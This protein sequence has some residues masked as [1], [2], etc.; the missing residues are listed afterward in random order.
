[1]EHSTDRRPRQIV[2]AGCVAILTGACSDLPSKGEALKIVR[3]EVKEEASCTL[4]ISLFSRLKMQHSSKAV[5]VP[6]EGGA[7]MDEAIKC[8]DALV[9]A[10]KTKHM[11]A[12]YMANWPDELEGPG[13]DSVSP[14]ER[15]ARYHLFK[16][17][18][19]MTGD[20]REGR[21]RCGEA[22]AEKV[23]RVTKK[24]DTTA[25]VRYARSVKLDRTVA[26][27]E[28]A[29]G[30]LTPPAPE[31]NVTLEKTDERWRVV[32]SDEEATP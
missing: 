27:I 21:F 30:Q 26:S 13:A 6:R 24:T 19:E 23:L 31:G 29:C 10:G 2:I 14:Y 32:S 16:G 25:T 8:L 28:A 17:C 7:P 9:A 22:R 4:P 18:V 15:R 12:D 20:L 3:S 5:C 1:M 11:P